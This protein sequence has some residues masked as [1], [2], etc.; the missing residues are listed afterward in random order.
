LR[1][2]NLKECFGLNH[3]SHVDGHANMRAVMLD[4]QGPEIRTGSFANGVKEVELL[5]GQIVSIFYG[6]A[7]D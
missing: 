7:T 2:T 1:A 6:V 3:T 5:I 4:T